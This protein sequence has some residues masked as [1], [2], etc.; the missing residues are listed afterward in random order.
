MRH[1]EHSSDVR[2]DGVQYDT[3]KAHIRQTFGATEIAGEKNRVQRV[4][5]RVRESRSQI[6]IMSYGVNAVLLSENSLRRV[7]DGGIFDFDLDD[8]PSLYTF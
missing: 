8:T 4:S 1:R 3:R 5:E 6:W 2:G 7:E